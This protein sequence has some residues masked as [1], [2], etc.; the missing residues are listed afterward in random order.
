MTR[1]TKRA[2]TRSLTQPV[3]V[4]LPLLDR[5]SGLHVWLIELVD[6]EFLALMSTN[7]PARGAAENE[8]IQRAVSAKMEANSVVGADAPSEAAASPARCFT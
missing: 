1:E 6:V 2:L 7:D 8:G 4:P 5:P 3:E